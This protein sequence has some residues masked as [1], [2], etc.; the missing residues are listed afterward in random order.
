MT[1]KCTWTGNQNSPSLSEWC[2]LKGHNCQTEI[3]WLPCFWEGLTGKALCCSA[4][5]SVR[6]FRRHFRRKRPLNLHPWRITRAVG[7]VQGTRLSRAASLLGHWLYMELSCKMMLARKMSQRPTSPQAD[8]QNQCWS[9]SGARQTPSF[10]FVSSQLCTTGE[11]RI[12]W[13]E[14]IRL[15]LESRSNYASPNHVLPRQR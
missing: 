13:Q 1:R 9:G 7:S 3:T 14:V 6:I 5:K 8:S 2:I 12:D 4:C 10:E 11:C 15:T